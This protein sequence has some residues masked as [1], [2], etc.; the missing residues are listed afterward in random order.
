MPDRFPVSN[1]DEFVHIGPA[2]YLHAASRRAFFGPEDADQFDLPNACIEFDMGDHTD[3][4]AAW[5]LRLA[6]FRIHYLKADGALIDDLAEVVRHVSYGLFIDDAIR[7]S[8]R[9]TRTTSNI[10]YLFINRSEIFFDKTS[11][12]KL[13]FLHAK[14][15]GTQKLRDYVS[16][17]QLVHLGLVGF[18]RDV[19]DVS[20]TI[21][22]LQISGSREKRLDFD[23]KQSV[24]DLWLHNLTALEN[25]DFLLRLPNLQHLKI[26]YC[27]KNPG[28]FDPVGP[29]EIEDC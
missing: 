18:Q 12:P 3:F 20:G 22:S 5:A 1:Y 19:I 17:H 21:E 27:K 14:I 4:I 26:Y 11:F 24:A 9:W 8:I 7:K 25:L 6:S 23:D 15:D 13:E 29:S 16:N 2:R 10:R 28:L